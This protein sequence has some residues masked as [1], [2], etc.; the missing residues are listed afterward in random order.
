MSVSQINSDSEFELA[1]SKTSLVVVD[2]Y[3]DWCGPCRDIAP[4]IDALSKSYP[5]VS[6]YKVNVDHLQSITK[7]E[8]V[9]GMPTFKLYRNKETICTIV[10]ANYAKLLDAVDRNAG[11]NAEELK[12]IEDAKSPY[13]FFPFE[14]YAYFDEVTNL[15]K[16]LEKIIQLNATFT[17]PELVGLQLSKSDISSLTHL[18]SVLQ[19]VASYHSSSFTKEEF[20][21]LLTMLRW[22]IKDRFPALDIIRLIIIHHQASEYF[23]DACNKNTEDN[24]F[25]ILLG[26]LLDEKVTENMP[27]SLMIWRFFANC[28]RHTKLRSCIVASLDIIVENS[29]PIFQKQT[30]LNV[31]VAIATTLLNAC[32]AARETKDSQLKCKIA[33]VL[34]QIANIDKIDPTVLLRALLGIGT[35]AYRDLEVTSEIKQMNQLFMKTQT[36]EKNNSLIQEIEKILG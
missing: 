3:A 29:F 30:N 27:N 14:D 31:R 24:V 28:F 25:D 4:R 12:Q 5:Q 19:D 9:T 36:T 35:A 13:K 20:S 22:P 2:F 26:S 1:I 32:I 7:R 16:V 11:P 21:V 8:N 34:V 33:K 23:S 10:G 18:V 17:T 15:P 6:F